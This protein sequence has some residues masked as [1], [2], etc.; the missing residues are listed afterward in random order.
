M[1]LPA[2]HRAPAKCTWKAVLWHV[3]RPIVL[4]VFSNGGCWVFEQTILLLDQDSRYG[5]LVQ[6]ARQ[7]AAI[8]LQAQVA[9]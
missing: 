4:W 8:C 9:G 5:C 6:P 3:H 1:Q 7:H 2:M